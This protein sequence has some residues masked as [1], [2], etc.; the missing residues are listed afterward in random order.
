MRPA[1]GELGLP[2]I[3][4]VGNWVSEKNSSRKPA[5]QARLPTRPST[6]RFTGGCIRVSGNTPSETV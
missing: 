3:P 1:K 2:E 4:S 6:V 5:E